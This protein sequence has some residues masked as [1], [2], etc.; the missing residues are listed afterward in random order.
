MARKQYTKEFKRD[1][2]EMSYSTDKTLAQFAK[3]MDLSPS[4]TICRT[5]QPRPFLN[6]Q[7]GSHWAVKAKGIHRT[8][9]GPRV[10]DV[11]GGL[12]RGY[13]KLAVAPRWPWVPVLQTRGTRGREERLAHLGEL[14]LLL[15]VEVSLRLFEGLGAPPTQGQRQQQTREQG[16]ADRQVRHGDS[17]W[18]GKG[19][20]GT[21]RGRGPPPPR[22]APGLRKGTIFVH[23]SL[24]SEALRPSM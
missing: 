15:S 23:H 21:H 22:R 13:E 17:L 1:I 18:N 8:P 20:A 3:D 16:T 11:V 4:R 12:G 14:F 2:V 19:G 24:C 10:Q 5:N 7:S 9:E 6:F